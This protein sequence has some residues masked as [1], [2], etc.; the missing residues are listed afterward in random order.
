MTPSG[1]NVFNAALICPDAKLAERFKAA[2]SQKQLVRLVDEDGSYPDSS[3]WTARLRQSRP[4]AVFIDVVS[5]PEK[6]IELITLSAES[7]SLVVVGLLPGEDANVILRALRAGASEFVSPPFDEES[8]RA[9]ASRVDRQRSSSSTQSNLRGKVAGFIAVKAG[10]GVTTVASNAAAGL[11][12][13]DR[14]VLLIDFDTSA[15]TLSFCW[16][17]T[18]TYSVLDAL[19]HCDK[20]DDSL[21]SALITNRNGVDLLL[22]PEAPELPPL[23]SE[24]YSQVVEF[25]RSRY[26]MVLLDLSQAYGPAAKATLHE[27][28]HI[29]VVCNPELPSL[30][31]TR[32]LI[33]YLEQEGFSRDQ[34]SIVLN[35]LSRRGELSP[36]DMER[37]FNFPISKVL[38]ADDATVHRALTAG[39]PVPENSALG[40]EIRQLCKPL[41]GD[42]EGDGKKKAAGLSL[43][44]LLSQ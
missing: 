18:H 8:I 17:V 39:K 35:R 21:W 44:A 29:F 5:N 25:A 37:V 40:R 43:S 7:P 38:P 20:L 34:F 10:Q 9:V 36:Q 6:A 16:R 13:S 11:A 30:H 31:L 32:K 2:V 4:D 14:R 22:G 41:L 15:G 1:S 12:A 24:R 28:D 33:A 26:E 23:Q 42:G 3:R 27:C 19:A